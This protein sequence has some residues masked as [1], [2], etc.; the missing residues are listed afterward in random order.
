MNH[1]ASKYNYIYSVDGKYLVYN[2]LS[3]AIAVLDNESIGQLSNLQDAELLDDFCSVGFVV[4]EDVD[5]LALVNSRR[6]A[7]MFGEYETINFTILPTT[8][9]RKRGCRV[10]RARV[11]CKQAGKRGL[12]WWGAP[13]RD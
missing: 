12:V 4:P 1:K 7:T 13:I 6:Y 2:L 10:H 8:G 5:E 11:R 3:D 9:C